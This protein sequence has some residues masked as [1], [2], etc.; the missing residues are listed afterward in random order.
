M[1]RKPYRTRQEIVVHFID[2]LLLTT[3][4]VVYFIGVNSNFAVGLP[5]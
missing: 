3:R 1:K 5:H 2:R 4:L